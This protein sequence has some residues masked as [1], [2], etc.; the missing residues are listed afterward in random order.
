MPHAAEH[1][2]ADPLKIRVNGA[3]LARFVL[4]VI[5]AW[6]LTYNSAVNR[7]HDSVNAC[8]FG[9]VHRDLPVARGWQVAEQR[10]LSQHQPRFAAIYARIH[11]Q[12]QH[13]N[14]TPCTARFHH[15]GVLG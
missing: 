3:A 6:A 2:E 7:F 5:V 12:L 11:A 9:R 13:L 15:P 10:A 1:R 14:N 4:L 8:Q